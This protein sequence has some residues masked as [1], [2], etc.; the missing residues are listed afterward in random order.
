MPDGVL[1]D[2]IGGQCEWAMRNLCA[3]LE[4]NAMQPADLVKPGVYLTPRLAGG[5]RGLC[6]DG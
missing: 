2:G 4:A 5:D 1:A 3:I 6:G